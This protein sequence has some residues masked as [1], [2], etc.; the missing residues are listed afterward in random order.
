MVRKERERRYISEY[1]LETWPAGDYEL[2]VELGP[3]PQ[4]YVTRYGM[5]KAAAM[6]RP[7]RPR[8]DAVK[9]TPEAYY[10][11][12]AKLRDIKAG[13]GDLSYYRNMIPDTKDL[14]YY[15]GQP[16]VARLVVPWTIDWVMAAARA[17][18]VEVVVF[19][20]DWIEDYVKE[21]QH[22]FTAEYR[23]ERKEKMELREIL[24]VD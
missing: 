7:T 9:W 1:M 12:E 5:S 13:I 4:E 20:K 22:Y 19:I 11:I 10:I 15:D 16:I 23:A 24:G 6:F 21:R 18:D 8:V 3:I 14:P 17:A 2:N